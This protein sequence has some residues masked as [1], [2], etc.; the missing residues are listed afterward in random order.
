MN[1]TFFVC[2][3]VEIIPFLKCELQRTFSLLVQFD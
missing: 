3:E 2:E 1:T